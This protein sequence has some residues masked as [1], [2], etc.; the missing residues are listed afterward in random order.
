MSHTRQKSFQTFDGRIMNTETDKPWVAH[1]SEWAE[2]ED[3]LIGNRQGLGRL[4]D[5]IDESIQTGISKIED[6]HIEFMGVKVVDKD[7]RVVTDT[8]KRNGILG[9]VLVIIVIGILGLLVMGVWK[10]A[11]LVR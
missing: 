3:Y 8:T 11:E 2:H 7:P 10:V 4:R 1:G 5:A 6:G 9:F